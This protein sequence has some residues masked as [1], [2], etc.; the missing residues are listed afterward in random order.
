VA[1][2]EQFFDER[3][4]RL[5]P[6]PAAYGAQNP[7]VAVLGMTYGATQ[8]NLA[9]SHFDE[10]KAFAGFR[11]RLD[12]LLKRVGV[13][14][15][16][17]NCDAK[18]KASEVDFHFGSVVR[19]S[20][21]G[22]DNNMKKYS[23]ESTFVL[24]GFQETN[25]ACRTLKNC[26]DVHLR[27]LPNRLKLVILLGNSNSYVAAIRRQVKRIFPKDYEKLGNKTHFAGGRFWVHLT[28]PSRG[29]YAYFDKYLDDPADFGQGPVREDAIKFIERSDF[30]RY[31][32]CHKAV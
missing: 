12:R 31:L 18:T 25:E 5:L 3:R 15:E 9:V 13:F 19:C 6:P 1:H 27:V 24:K 4:F 17:D 26:V 30:R 32:S 8:N 22:F 11:D 10:R 20:L 16:G 14:H 23:S 21:M 7:V 29:N 2:T 28:H